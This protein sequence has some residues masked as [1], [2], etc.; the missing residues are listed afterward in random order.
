MF[1]QRKQSQAGS[2]SKVSASQGNDHDNDSDQAEGTASSA[3]TD[4]ITAADNVLNIEAVNFN[5]GA[6]TFIAQ[7]GNH[8]NMKAALLIK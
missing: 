7:S 8:G 4:S 5:F 1:K 3:A 2:D 6:K